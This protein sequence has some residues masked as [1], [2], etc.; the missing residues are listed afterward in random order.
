MASFVPGQ[1]EGVVNP[2]PTGTA[3]GQT[4]EKQPVP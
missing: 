2:V 4:L 1:D 3:S